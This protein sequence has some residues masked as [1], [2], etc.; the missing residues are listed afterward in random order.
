MLP[1][2][3]NGKITSDT[4]FL[5]ANVNSWSLVLEIKGT[6]EESVK[7]L[8]FQQLSIYRPGLLLTHRPNE[9]RLLESL[10][11][12]LAAIGILPYPSIPI[13]TLARFIVR[14]A[15]GQESDTPDR[16]RIFEHQDLFLS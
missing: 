13:N 8:E 5:G 12:C 3:Y 14:K 16:V 1:L 7:N 15:M 2:L 6:V 9:T 4:F 10:A 11:Q